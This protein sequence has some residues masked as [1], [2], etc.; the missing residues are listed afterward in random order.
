MVDGGKTKEG[1]VL[2]SNN[3]YT[4]IHPKQRAVMAAAVK[5]IPDPC[6]AERTTVAMYYLRIFTAA[7]F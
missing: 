1:E 3:G 5:K 2:N 6:I 4:A 7:M